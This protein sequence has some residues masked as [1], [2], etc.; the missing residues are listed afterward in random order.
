MSDS[1]P[2]KLKIRKLIHKVSTKDGILGDYDYKYLFT[3]QLPFMKKNKVTQPF[4]GLDSSMPIVLGF[5]LG[6]QHSLAMLAGIITPPLI[7]SSSAYF[8][9]DQQQYLVTASLI[10]SGFLSM[11]Q[12]TRFHIYKTPYYLGSDGTYLPCP[13]GYGAILGTSCVCGLLEV[14]ISFIPPKFL[15]KLFPQTVTGTVVLLMGISLIKAGFEDWIGGSGCIGGTC[16]SEGAPHALPYGSAQFIGLGFLVYI[17]IV[18]FEKWGAPIMKSC[19]V[20]LG[21]LVGCIVAGAC[22]YFDKTSIDAAPAASF[23]WTTTFKLTVYGPAVLPMLIVYVVLVMET[24]GDLTAT[25]EVSRLETEG[26]LYE[27]RIQGGVLGDGF[28]SIIAGLCTITPMSTFAQNNGVISITK[29]ANRTAGY[30]CCCILIIMG[31]FTK[32]AA[33]LVAI[34]KPVL[35][36][37]TSFLFTSVAVSGLKIISNSPFTRRDRF[38]LTASLLP[39]LGCIL[40]PDWFENVFTYSGNNHALIGFLDAITVIMESSY[41][42]GGIIATILNLFLPQVLDF[43]EEEEE[44]KIQSDLD[45]LALDD[46]VHQYDDEDKLPGKKGSKTL[47]TTYEASQIGSDSRN[48]SS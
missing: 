35:G 32:F 46:Y 8:T 23:V 27:S 18:I 33:S 6:L 21:L 3:P 40:V 15:K 25:A 11:I 31:I 45:E 1:N 12:I 22:G 19:S 41:A 13:D 10:V 30:W 44:D 9:T 28:N 48:L 38:V 29:C 5:I 26:P 2:F 47:E 20:I 24:I 34:P 39:G 36:G 42:L 16:P 43:E 4:F 17:T 7:V 14:F 37:M